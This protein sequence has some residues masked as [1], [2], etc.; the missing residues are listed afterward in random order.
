MRLWFDTNYGIYV[1]DAPKTMFLSTYYSP[2]NIVNLFWPFIMMEEP[3]FASSPYHPNLNCLANSKLLEVIGKSWGNS[4]TAV[5]LKII[6]DITGWQTCYIF[7][8]YEEH[9]ATQPMNVWV[10]CFI[11]YHQGLENYLVDSPGYIRFNLFN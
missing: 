8:L 7:G 1:G 10:N 6:C 9:A 5:T 4:V 3:V 2:V 11:W